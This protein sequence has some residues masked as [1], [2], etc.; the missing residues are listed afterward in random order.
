MM[1]SGKSTVGRLLAQRLGW[2]FIDTDARIVR[3]AGKSIA[4]IFEEDGEEAFR[5]LESRIVREAAEEHRAVI[6]LGGGA[7][8]REENRDA[9]WRHG[10]VVWLSASPEEH[11]ARVSKSE[12]RPLLESH[13][14]PVEAARRILK[15][16]EPLYALADIKED[17]T[18]RTPDAIAEAL[19]R[20]RPWERRGERTE[21]R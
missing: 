19:A 4:R 15:F 16:R 9:I 11:F 7:I 14:D 18:G 1:G 6:A 2:R 13:G 20:A 5:D 10:F 3:A 21:G 8:L 12:R 17:T